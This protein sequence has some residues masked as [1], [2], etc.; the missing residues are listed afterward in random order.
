M[1][2]VDEIFGPDVSEFFPRFYVKF[3]S[4][5]VVFGVH[6]LRFHGCFAFFDSGVLYQRDNFRLQ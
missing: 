3:E 5:A 4:P 6:E 1:G 2:R